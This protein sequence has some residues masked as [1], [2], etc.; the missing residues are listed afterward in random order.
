M[1]QLAQRLRLDLPNPLAR[2]R[3]LLAD[4]F[5]RVVSIHTDA[6]PHAQH[7][8]LARCMRLARIRVVTSRRFD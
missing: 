5:E 2:H 1:L 6:E 3:E 7:A 8:F 4:F